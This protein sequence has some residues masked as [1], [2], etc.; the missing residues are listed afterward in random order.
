LRLSMII[1]YFSY[2]A[3]MQHSQMVVVEHVQ[4]AQ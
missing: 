2:F 1:A 3:I 4:K